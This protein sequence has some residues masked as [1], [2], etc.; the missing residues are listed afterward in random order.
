MMH[1]VSSLFKKSNSLIVLILLAV[2][3]SAAQDASETFKNTVHM[4]N[5]VWNTGEYELLEQS[6]HPDYFKQEGDMRIQ[7]V[8]QLKSYIK[9]FR[10]SLPDVKITY[11]EELYAKNKAAIRFTLEGTPVDTGKK[12]KAQGIVLFRF[13]DGKIV[14]DLSV[15]DELSALKQQGYTIVPPAATDY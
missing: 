5:R 13:L 11:V 8:E 9:E 12:Y 10:E 1:R 7:G 3:L 6:V 15:F 4:F 2:N 14:E